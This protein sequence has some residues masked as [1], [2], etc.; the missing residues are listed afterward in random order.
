MNY[1]SI[2]A[3]L[4]AEQAIGKLHTMLWIFPMLF[5][6]SALVADI[7]HYFGRKRGFTIAHWLVILG[8]ISCIPVIITGLA[9]QTSFDPNSYLVAKH[10]FLGYATGIAGSFYAGLRI[11]AMIWNLPLKPIHYVFLTF[12]LFALASWASD[13]GGLITHGSFPNSP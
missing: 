11:S 5:F 7:F 4:T 2:F 12:L 13:Y 1:I 6:A 9:A 3:V 8:V 10:R